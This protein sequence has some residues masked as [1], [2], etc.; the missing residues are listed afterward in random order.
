VYSQGLHAGIASLLQEMRTFVALHSN[1]SLRENS[2]GR[3][4]LR[5][6]IGA[7]ICRDL[8]LIHGRDSMYEAVQMITRYKGDQAPFPMEGRN[9]QEGCKLSGQSPGLFHRPPQERKSRN[10]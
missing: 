7:A 5:T 8:A 1:T 10:L 9:R 6:I 3:K 4:K 2:A